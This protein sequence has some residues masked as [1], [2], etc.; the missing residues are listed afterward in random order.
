M[1]MDEYAEKSLRPAP[2]VAWLK[3]RR[4]LGSSL[5]CESISFPEAAFLSVAVK[6]RTQSPQA[7]WRT[8]SRQERLWGT[9]ISLHQ[10]FCGKTMQAVTGQPI[11]EFSCVSPGDQLLAKGPADSG[12][13]IGLVRVHYACA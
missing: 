8:V 1:S 11:N 5:M 12:H 10:G 2:L 9:G 6:S 4:T 7:L 3:S 13:K